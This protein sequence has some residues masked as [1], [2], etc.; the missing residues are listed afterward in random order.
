MTNWQPIETAPKDQI[1]K[2]LFLGEWE[3]VDGGKYL[4]SFLQGRF[5]VELGDGS[6]GELWLKVHPDYPRIP[7][8]VIH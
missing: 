2:W 6:S 5:L 1:V 3:R 7:L 4:P 8:A